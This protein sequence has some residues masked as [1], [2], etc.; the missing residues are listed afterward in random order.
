MIDVL[1]VTNAEHQAIHVQ[2]AGICEAVEY[3]AEIVYHHFVVG[4]EELTE[5]W[6]KQ[7]N[8]G[9]EGWEMQEA[10]VGTSKVLSGEMGEGI[11]D[12]GEGPSGLSLVDKGKGK[13]KEVMEEEALQ[14]K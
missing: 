5:G 12:R 13:E 1:E 9:V 2:F 8:Q 11:K 14:E 3:I 4:N 7:A 10:G 6:G